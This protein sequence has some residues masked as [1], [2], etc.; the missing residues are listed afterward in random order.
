MSKGSRVPAV[1][2]RIGE[3]ERRTAPR[4]GILQRCFVYPVQASATDAWRCIAYSIS[5]TGIGVTLP[6]PLH[7]GTVLT[8]EA[9]GLPRACPLKVRITQTKQVDF[10]WFTG[11]ELLKR[12]SDAELSIWRNGPVDWLDQPGL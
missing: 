5:G 7:E 10:F 2:K 1:E 4:F 12:L 8:I 3:I 9:W 11:C 6:I